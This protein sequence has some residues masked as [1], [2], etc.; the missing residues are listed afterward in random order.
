MISK[1]TTLAIRRLLSEG[2]LSQRKIALR[3]GI[4]R[5]AVRNVEKESVREQSKEEFFRYPKGPHR[6]CYSCGAFVQ[7]P[8]LACQIRNWKK[9]ERGEKLETEKKM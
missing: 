2:K 6:R 8:C 3:L 4:S 9:E 7:L 1:T 5:S